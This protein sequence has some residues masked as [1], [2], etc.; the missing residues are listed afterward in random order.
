ML[1]VQQGECSL[2]SSPPPFH[3][4]LQPRRAGSPWAF[5]LSLFC[6]GSVSGYFCTGSG[7]VCF[8]GNAGTQSTVV[9]TQTCSAFQVKLKTSQALTVG[10]EEVDF[11]LQSSCLCVSVL[12]CSV[13]CPPCHL[14]AL[15]SR[16]HRLCW[17]RGEGKMGKRRP[18]PTG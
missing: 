10:L 6:P 14:S 17:E 15:F 5:H 3:L 16:A 1:G 13:C 12:S 18:A 4:P 7:G 9:G 11:L 8:P 2:S